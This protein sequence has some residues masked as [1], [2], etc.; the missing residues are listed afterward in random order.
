MPGV[1]GVALDPRDTPVSPVRALPCN[2]QNKHPTSTGCQ[3]GDAGERGEGRMNETRLGRVL[4]IN[5]SCRHAG[6]CTPPWMARGKGSRN[7]VTE[8]GRGK[9][10]RKRVAEKGRGKGSR[11][12]VAEKGRG[13]GSRKRVTAMAYCSRL[14]LTRFLPS[15]VS[16]DIPYVLAR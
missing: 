8:K 13:N 14:T 5:P 11:K 2:L 3:G 1:Q 15:A 9:G 10:S 16:P 12:R 6:F 7:R 4:F